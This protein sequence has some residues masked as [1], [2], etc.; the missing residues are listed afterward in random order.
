MSSIYHNIK[1]FDEL[2]AIGCEFIKGYIIHHPF[3]PTNKSRDNL[4]ELVGEY[5]WIREYLY[6]LN[7][8]GF[9]TIMSQPGNSK[10]IDIYSNYYEYKKSYIIDST[11]INLTKLDGNFGIMQR[12]EVEGFMKY[13]KAKQLYSMLK[14]DP[15][16]IIL[17][18]TN[19]EN[20]ILNS[21]DKYT[22]LSYETIDTNIRFMEI[23]AEY[24]ETIRLKY[25]NY[26][27]DEKLKLMKHVIRRYFEINKFEI[28]KH[29]PNILDTDI[30][31][32]TIMDRIWNRN[33][34]LWEKI[35][36][37]FKKISN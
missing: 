26:K 29:I 27:R 33:D 31:G 4:Y 1:T 8:L 25:K 15:N 7:K 36:I 9:Y 17:I 28:K 3:L 6:E 19:K 22:T 32:I 10:S 21:L 5:S 13:D 11:K 16:I 37:C 35:L 30:V 34:Y 12:A 23:E 24:N 18:S 2:C 14:N 20:D